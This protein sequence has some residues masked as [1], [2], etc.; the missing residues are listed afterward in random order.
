LEVQLPL[1]EEEKKKNQETDQDINDE[2][3]Y[4]G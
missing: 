2:P 3:S 4:A 1:Q